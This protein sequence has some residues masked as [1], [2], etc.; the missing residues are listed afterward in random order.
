MVQESINIGIHWEIKRKESKITRVET[1]SIKK[2]VDTKIKS[3]EK[4]LIISI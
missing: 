4:D 1:N 3:T 2:D